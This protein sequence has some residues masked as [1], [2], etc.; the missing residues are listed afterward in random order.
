MALL[1]VFGNGFVIA[2]RLIFR[3]KNRIHSFYIKNLALADL[4]MGFFLLSIA[5]HDVRFRGEF[6]AHSHSW[7]HSVVCKVSGKEQS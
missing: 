6:L 4:L 2:S 7:R 5:I 3:E 1:G